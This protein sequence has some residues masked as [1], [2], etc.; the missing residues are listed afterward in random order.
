MNYTT[1]DPIY[2]VSSLTRELKNLVEKK[3]RF[4]RVQGEISNLKRPFS[5]HAYFTLK[6]DG[7]QLSSVLFKGTARYLEQNIEE[8]QQVVCHGRISIY[9]PRGNYQ[10]IVDSVDFQGTGLLQQQ[11]E[12]LKNKLAGEGL[13]AADRKKEI[14][15]FPK[16]IVL[17]TSPSGAAVHDFLKIWRQRDFP[18]NLVVFPVRV[19]G[20]GAANEIAN[21]LT[22]VNREFSQCDLIVLCRGGGSLEDLWAF[23]EEVLARAIA[24]SQLPVV[25]AIGH[26]VDYTISDFCADFRAATPTAA[27]EELIPDGV[28]LRLQIQRL[29]RSLL[30]SVHHLIE[31]YEYRLLQNRRLL[32]DMDFLFT[33]VS[34]RLDHVTQKLH[35][36][37]SRRLENEQLRCRNL[38][39][40]LQNNS[41][42]A[43]L[44][45]QQQRL[46][47]AAEK[48]LFLFNKSMEDRQAQLAQLTAILDAV[49]PLATLARGYSISSRI[50]PASKRKT[51]LRDSRQA[52]E[53]DR[54]EIRLN[55]GKLNCKVLAVDEFEKK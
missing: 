9:E 12:K 54:I 5:G 29:Q 48:L 26:E 46:N 16:E 6:D 15:Q 38:A 3:Y 39:A 7:A 33:N 45:I 32:G 25:T 21:A 30:K 52:Q 37:I 11:F 24:R 2:S 20:S 51:L 47:F 27:A 44:K 35:T 17:L 22:T 53:G 23:N 8:G 31:S 13:F 14:P 19:Q 40:R 34:L 49:S 4:I 10:L 42:S 41:P 18:T 1:K 43:K 55:R 28:S 50:D 36:I